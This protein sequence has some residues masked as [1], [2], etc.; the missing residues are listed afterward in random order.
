[1][2]EA[3][4]MELFIQL[5]S[6]KFRAKV[7]KRVDVLCNRAQPNRDVARKALVALARVGD[8]DDIPLLAKILSD[9]PYWDLRMYAAGVLGSIPS[10]ASLIVLGKA[11]EQEPFYFVRHFIQAARRR[12]SGEWQIAACTEDLRENPKDT[13]AYVGRAAAY[14]RMGEVQKAI[15]DCNKAIELDPREQEALFLRGAAYLHQHEWA[16]AI[17]D[18]T[19]V[20]RLDPRNAGSHTILANAY[21]ETGEWNKAI[22]EAKARVQLQ[23]DDPEGHNQLAWWFATC[24]S[25]TV[26]DGAE[27]LRYATRACELTGWKH[28]FYMDTLAA[29]YAENG[30]FGEAAKWQQRALA[31]VT[32]FSREEF[33]HCKRRLDLYKAGKPYRE[34]PGASGTP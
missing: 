16:K 1:M 24:P 3:G 12:S 30:Q 13:V 8:T 22:A 15:D 19:E 31:D 9:S 21:A 26:R 14:L 32:A 4:T 5:P 33:E 25:D 11:A 17:A 34:K 18:H 6:S 7:H 2:G 28:P 20:I 27:A 10:K 29:A 23:P